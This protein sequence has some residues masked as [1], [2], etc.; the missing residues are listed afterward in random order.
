MTLVAGTL[1]HPWF[2]GLFGVAFGVLVVAVTHYFARRKP[3]PT[4]EEQ[5]SREILLE[6]P[7]RVNGAVGYHL[8]A[9]IHNESNRA[10]S[11]VLVI[12]SFPGG[13]QM[14]VEAVNN[15]PGAPSLADAPI[16][17]GA[18]RA[19]RLNFDAAPS[20]S[21]VPVLRVASCSCD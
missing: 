7:V 17:P 6:S 4:T 2:R 15:E 18:W 10:L 12:A 5:M 8:D 14:Q 20:T 1:N 16:L 19:V 13:S 21:K 3:C 9:Y 11:R